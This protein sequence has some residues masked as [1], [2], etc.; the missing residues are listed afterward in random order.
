MTLWQD[1]RSTQCSSGYFSGTATF[2]DP[3]ERGVLKSYEGFNA[4]S[5]FISKKILDIIEE[6]PK[7]PNREITETRQGVLFSVTYHTDDPKRNT[8]E[9]NNQP[10]TRQRYQSELEASLP[11]YISQIPT[12]KVLFSRREFFETHYPGTP[13]ISFTVVDA[14]DTQIS[15]LRVMPAVD[16]A[17]RFASNLCLP[18]VT[19]HTYSIN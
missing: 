15:G 1:L 10:L 2:N 7:D 5:Q 3:P 8:Y 9:C 12:Q 6:T 4:Q 14:T 16:R 11:Y 17:M 19:L 18:P 13:V